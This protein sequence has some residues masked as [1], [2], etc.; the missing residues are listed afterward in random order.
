[1]APHHRQAT[2]DSSTSASA[3]RHTGAYFDTLPS[4]KNLA[5]WFSQ[6]SQQRYIDT[7]VG[8]SGLTRRQATCFVRLWGYAHRQAGEPLPIDILSQSLT[9]FC[10][11]HA[12]AADLFY[13]DRDTGTPRAAGMMID[14]LVA[15]RLVKR[16]PF[17]GTC[18][19]LC[20]QVP[21]SFLPRTPQ[22]ASPQT[23]T[24][25]FNPRC[26]AP[27]VA[28]LL[29][30]NYSWTSDRPE[31]GSFKITKTLRQWAS[32]YPEGLRVLREGS[33]DEPIGLSVLFPVH[34]SCEA[35][36]HLPPSSSLYL[37][38]PEQEDPI[39]VATPGED[40]CVVFVRSWD[41]K[42]SYRNYAAACQLL[43][44]SQATLAQM[45]QT[46]SGLC[47]IYTVSIHPRLEAFALALGFKPMGA[48]PSSALRWLYMPVDRFLALDVD[49][50]LVEF[51]FSL[52]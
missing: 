27:L 10:C 11:S 50:T 14:Q 43:K 38:T 48:D 22:L 23:Y 16:E 19:R 46:F 26:D 21:D 2:L 1:M 3:G 15:K 7:I 39:S 33:D 12:E 41:I 13:C 52:G 29:E 25:A 35:Q 28:A 30:E 20:L 45:Q 8:Q 17:D 34:A 47:D 6:A 18:T 44:D 37:N 51:D 31:A 40:C 24:D 9:V 32:Q 49:E 5:E 4:A 42:P 36:F